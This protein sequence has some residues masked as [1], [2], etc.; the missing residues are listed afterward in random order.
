MLAHVPPYHQTYAAASPVHQ[1]SLPYNYIKMYVRQIDQPR[2]RQP[3]A[4]SVRHG[5]A[6]PSAAPHVLPVTSHCDPLVAP[7][8]PPAAASPAR[9]AHWRAPLLW[10][11]PSPR[12]TPTPAPRHSGMLSMSICTIAHGLLNHASQTVKQLPWHAHLTGRW[13]RGSWQV[14]GTRW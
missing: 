8:G 4:A 2:Q 9:C 3:P 6:R 7:P 14:D 1:N 10:R 11:H 5:A 12:V 13:K